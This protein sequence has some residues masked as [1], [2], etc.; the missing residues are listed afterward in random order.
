MGWDENGWDG[1]GWE[2]KRREIRG[3]VGERN[4]RDSGG[5]MGVGWSNGCDRDANRMECVRHIHS[6][7]SG[8]LHYNDSQINEIS[9]TYTFDI[10]IVFGI[11]PY[12]YQSCI[13][14]C[15]CEIHSYIH[16]F[17]HSSIYS[18]SFIHHRWCHMWLIPLNLNFAIHLD[19]I[20][21]YPMHTRIQHQASSLLPSTSSSS[22]TIGIITHKWVY[23][24]VMPYDINHQFKH[25]WYEWMYERIF[26]ATICRW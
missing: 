12:V 3:G 10:G 23:N 16:S 18:H 6:N 11:D 2:Q 8:I 26:D 19:W 15:R 7:S 4:G 13:H 22:S 9:P 14:K 17:I 21:E 5:C 1:M 24:Q 20:D 25:T